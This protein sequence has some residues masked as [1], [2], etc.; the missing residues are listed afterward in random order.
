VILGNPLIA[1]LYPFN[2]IEEG[3]GT[4]NL[5]QK[6]LF[7][8][9]MPPIAKDIN[10]LKNISISK[11][12]NII[13]KNIVLRKEKQLMFLKQNLQ[14]KIIEDQL[15]DPLVQQ[16]INVFKNIIETEI[17]ANIPNAFWH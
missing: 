8:F 7:K 11:E 9:I 6:V 12:I 4:K 13:S 2:I 17:C 14:Y 3:I 10:L 1:L 5:E 16:K 15:K